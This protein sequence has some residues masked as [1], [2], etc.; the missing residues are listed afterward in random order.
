MHLRHC[1]AQAHVYT[2]ITALGSFSESSLKTVEFHPRVGR[3]IFR[4]NLKQPGA[5]SYQLHASGTAWGAKNLLLV[6][7]KGPGPQPSMAAHLIFTGASQD[8]FQ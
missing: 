8:Q 2:E 7:R 4:P 5:A 3:P 6:R 1:G